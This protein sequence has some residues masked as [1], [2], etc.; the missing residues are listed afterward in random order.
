MS[1]QLTTSTHD[2]DFRRKIKTPDEL[3]AIVGP[4]PRT[5][6]VV[7]CHGA[8]DL[9][10]PGHV[11]HLIYAKSKA[12]ILVA[13]LTSDAHISKADYR[14]FVPQQLRAMNLAALE[15]VDYVVIDQNP[16]PLEN[17]RFLQPDFFAKGYEYSGDGIH[18]KT[19]EEIEALSEYDGEIIFTPG[20]LVYSSTSFI[21]VAPPDIA[22][23]KL[24]T[25]MDSEGVT[26][27]A[28][29]D[30]LRSFTDIRVCVVGD[31]IVDS[32]VYCNLISSGTA[33][34]PTLSV[35]YE[36]QHD[37]SGGAAVVAKHLRRG[38]ARVK[39]VTVLGDD[40]LKQFVLDDMESAGVDCEPSVDSTRV[41]TQKKVFIASGHRMLKVDEVD[42]RPI[43]ERT[44]NDLKEAVSTSDVDA[45]VFSDY[46][47]G[48]FNPETIRQLREGL[49]VGPLK[50][51]DSQVASRWGNILDFKGFDL[52]TPNEREA[53][54]ALGDQD[55]II[56][57]LAMELYKKAECKTLV[58]KLGDRGILTYRAPSEDVRSFFGIDSLAGNVVDPV[59]AGDALL[60]YSVMGLVATGSQVIASALGSIAAAVACEHEGNNPVALEDVHKKLETVERQATYR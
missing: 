27:D 42:N 59:G 36:R 29:K 2:K 46:R 38:G 26:F 7:M 19:R 49:P 34:T 58:L 52:I 39:F 55:S 10:H 4:R 37:F 21:E 6:S 20:D 56:R 28:L 60:A 31:T 50:V 18:P 30:A 14:P 53:R 41:T 22:V 12:D 8:F 3:L 40:P 47:H 24:V 1:E 44:L 13:S 43:S 45:F 17:I 35:A 16:E 23:E 57:P 32:Y 54:F 33:K 15:V 11:R 48:I 25:L 5:Q 9:V 51:A